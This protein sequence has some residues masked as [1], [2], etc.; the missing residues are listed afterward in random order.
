MAFETLS[1]WTSQF[2]LERI[3]SGDFSVFLPIFFLVISIAMYSIIIWHF[4]RFIARR[5]CFKLTPKKHK[6]LI[7]FLKYFFLYPFV[8]LL[9]FAGFSFIMLFLTRAYEIPA[10]LSTS[11]A[12]I[13]AIR[14]TA[15]YSED[16]SKDVAK[17][18]PFA[19]LGIFL[20]DPSYFGFEETIAK[21]MSIPEHSTLCIQFLLFII[22]I[23]WI[24]RIMLTI[25]YRLLPEQCQSPV[26]DRIVREKEKTM[27]KISFKIS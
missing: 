27:E 23:E 16:L 6:K 8:A 11:F 22:L 24:L 12:V 18:L 14:I 13:V 20:V 17:M 15:Y 1:E 4:Y 10:V 2:S 25:R 3:L 19:L 7:G 9:F 5:D 26:E 21:F